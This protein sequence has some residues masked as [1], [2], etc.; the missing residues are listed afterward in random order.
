[1]SFRRS[2]LTDEFEESNPFAQSHFFHVYL[3]FSVPA[4]IH[5]AIYSSWLGSK[6]VN[7]PEEG[8][9]KSSKKKKSNTTNHLLHLSQES[10]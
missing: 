5:W 4:Y 7:L 10:A 8:A 9:R 3:G 1:M 2:V 6:G